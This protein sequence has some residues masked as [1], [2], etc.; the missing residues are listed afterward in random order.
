MILILPH[1][2]MKSL[3]LPEVLYYQIRHTDMDL[4]VLTTQ[5]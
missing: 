5:Q 3:T 2:R 4:S 1:H